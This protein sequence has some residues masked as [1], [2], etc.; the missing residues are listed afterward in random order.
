MSKLTLLFFHVNHRLY[1][2]LHRLS[3]LLENYLGQVNA[4]L[5]FAWGL[6][7]QVSVNGTVDPPRSHFV[8]LKKI[9]GQLWLG[10]AVR[11]RSRFYLRW[12]CALVAGDRGS[13]AQRKAYWHRVSPLE[14]VNELKLA[15]QVHTEP[16]L[17]V[18]L[19]WSFWS[20]ATRLTMSLD[21][22]RRRVSGLSA[23]QVPPPVSPVGHRSLGAGG[24]GSGHS[25]QIPQ[26]TEFVPN[27]QGVL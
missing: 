18:T 27:A 4:A 23:V 9:W 3:K 22:S 19:P 12:L 26:L 8:A 24:A 21:R 2:C 14:P 1:W 20:A 10:P 5:I 11:T 6:Q 17:R 16:V 13:L 25:P 7:L 15:E